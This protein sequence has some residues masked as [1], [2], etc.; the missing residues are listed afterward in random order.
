[1]ARCIP[2]YA[3]PAWLEYVT[4]RKEEGDEQAAALLAGLPDKRK[5][6]RLRAERAPEVKG[7]TKAERKAE[8]NAR[9]AEI[10]ATV[11]ER[12]GDACEWCHR[13]GFVLEWA[14]IFGGGE[15]RHR[16]AVEN[17]AGI[18]ADC[19]H[20]GWERGNL[21]VLR[22]AKE[23]AIRH[24]FRV[25]LAAIEKRTAKV[26]EARRTPSVPVRLVVGEGR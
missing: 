22:A 11:M 12:A 8:R 5:S 7:A 21:D 14:H 3:E 17:T 26:E 24:G 18:C 25:A 2:A 4:D 6:K 16:E 23:W 19:H 20:R 13:S 1:M 10:R 9:A 15:R